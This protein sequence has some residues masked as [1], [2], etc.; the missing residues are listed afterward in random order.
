MAD[1]AILLQKRKALIYK[2]LRNSGVLAHFLLLGYMF[3]LQPLLNKTMAIVADANISGRASDIN[4]AVERLK[5]ISGEDSQQVN[6]KNKTHLEVGKLGVRFLIIANEMQDMRDS[7]GALASRFNFL[8]TTESFLGR[9]DM[10]LGERLLEEVP[11]IFVWALGG[12]ARLRR[13]GYLLEHSASKTSREDFE[14]MSSPMTTFIDEWC[15]LGPGRYVPIDALWRAHCHWS[16]RNGRGDGFSKQKFALKVKSVVPGIVKDRRRM[17]LSTLG[18]E[19]DMDS[20]GDDNRV[21][22]YL[23]IDLQ[24]EYKKR[25]DNMDTADR[26]W[27]H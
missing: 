23:G 27:T 7:S 12:L 10:R 17:D 3:G 8:V 11:G 21:Q 20:K 18:F 9:E 22:L 24:E 1:T 16:K 14:A 15:Q 13:R 25:V 2:Q 19:Y 4:R 26:G 6:R 5:S